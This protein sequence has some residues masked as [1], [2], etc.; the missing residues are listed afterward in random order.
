MLKMSRIV[1]EDETWTK[2]GKLEVQ[3]ARKGSLGASFG[4]L[5][6]SVNRGTNVRDCEILVDSQ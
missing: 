1:R 5:E 6:S 3:G 2:L 4:V